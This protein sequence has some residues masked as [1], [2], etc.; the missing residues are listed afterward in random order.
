[1]AARQAAAVGC[2]P[3]W[4]T[5]EWES[6]TTQPGL[7]KQPCP[8]LAEREEEGDGGLALQIHTHLKR[9]GVSSAAW[10]L[11]A[12]PVAEPSHEVS[13]L[14]GTFMDDH[15]DERPINTCQWFRKYARA[16][17]AGVPII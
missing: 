3:A 8:P 1:M 7:R 10:C 2:E 16:F 13:R 15:H 4:R 6:P 12:L 14:S 17:I 9:Q 11:D 5:W